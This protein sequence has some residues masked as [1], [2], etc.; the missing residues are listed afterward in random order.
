MEK[1]AIKLGGSII[2]DKKSNVPKARKEVIY[3]LMK[4][5]S[6]SGTCPFLIANGAG[7]FGHSFAKSYLEGKIKDINLIHSSVLKLHEIVVNEAQ[8]NE[9]KGESI[10]PFKTCKK[11]K[12]ILD[13]AQFFENAKRILQKENIVFSYGDMIPFDE[14]FVVLSAD[15]I[16]VEFGKKFHADKIVMVTEVDGVLDQNGRV[17]KNLSIEEKI[18][19]VLIGKEDDVTG[20]FEGKVKKLQSAA[21]SG[22]DSFIVG[23]MIKNNLKNFLDGKDFIGTSIFGK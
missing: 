18:P 19:K 16:T 21:M 23:G 11:S 2:T 7:S 6:E 10:Y 8:K 20:G 5:I 13:M 12:N 15:T 22:I 14:K 4:E 3:R 17:I 9:L 1:I